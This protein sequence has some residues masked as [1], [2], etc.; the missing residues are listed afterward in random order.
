MARSWR[1]MALILTWLV[2]TSITGIGLIDVLSANQPPGKVASDAGDVRPVEKSAELSTKVQ[3]E[4]TA[5]RELLD[6]L[7]EQN[8]GKAC[9]TNAWCR[10]LKQIADL[11]SDAVPELIQELDSTDDQLMLRCLGFILRDINDKRAIPSLIRAIPKTLLPP[12][13]D[14]RLK[15]E[16]PDLAYFARTNDLFPTYRASRGGEYGFG[17]PVREICGTLHKLTGKQFGET[18]LYN[19]FL[20]GS[21]SQQQRKRVSFQRIAETWAAWWENQWMDYVQDKVYSKIDLPE[22]IDEGAILPPAVNSRFRTTGLRRNWIL[23]TYA[24]PN[25][26]HVFYDFDVGRVAALPEKWRNAGDIESHLDEILFWATR[27]GFDVMGTEYVSPDGQ[28]VFALQ[29]IGLHTWELG[30]DRWK[31]DAA[32]FTLNALKDEGR[33]AKDLLLHFDESTKS[34]SPLETA[35]FLFV[36]RHGTPGLLFVGVEVHDYRLKPDGI[37]RGDNE[38]NPVAFN[39]GRRFGFTLV[40]ELTP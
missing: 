32:D 33:P 10:T 25:S 31:M 8:T 23:E 20:E 5:T 7:K 2:G 39:K 13:P 14:M 38:L 18:E 19:V 3:S 40:E 28:K 22:Q 34:I 30:K 9:Y 21:A 12:C 24:N 35:T 26:K 11:G 37:L 27:E 15:V 6:Q 4:A 29:P 1:G 16:D 36:T 17:R